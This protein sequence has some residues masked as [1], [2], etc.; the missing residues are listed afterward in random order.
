MTSYSGD[1]LKVP[2]IP[3]SWGELFDKVSI[4]EIK[5]EYALKKSAFNNIQKEYEILNGL[6][7]E[8]LFGNAELMRLRLKLKKINQNIWHIEKEIR[9]KEAAS[10]F[11]E[12]FIEL[13]RNTYL[14]NDSRAVV[15]KRINVILKSAIVE[16]KIY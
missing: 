14:L 16:E 8:A 9:I 4:L 10:T 15:K 11:D 7:P 5:K 13:A 6:I 3:V 1:L 2:Q 12:S